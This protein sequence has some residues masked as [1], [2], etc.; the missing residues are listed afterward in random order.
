MILYH[1]SAKI[2]GQP[3]FGEGK[4]YNDYGLGFYCTENIDIA[5]E[6]AVEEDRD[7]Y[8]NI[9]DLDLADLS[10]LNLQSPA[11]CILHWITILL[12]NRHFESD[13]A[14]ARAGKEYL[15]KW[16]GI[17]YSSYDII[18]GYRADDSYFSF[19][20]DFLN[21]TISVRHLS[22]A[23]KLGK[24]GE[25]V[26]L[27]SQKAFERIKYVAE[28]SVDASEWYPKRAARDDTARIQY[29]RM[30]KSEWQRGDIYITHILDEEIKPDDV[31]LQ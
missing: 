6:W 22:E 21:G 10:V 5:R 9:Y 4:K 14:L 16:F 31:R 18:R 19:A 28:E 23:M 1:G 15:T 8:L 12:Q 3:V 29:R 7:G 24:L 20:Q 25:Q 13:S 2:V 26:V 17:D 30:N 11:F 27:K